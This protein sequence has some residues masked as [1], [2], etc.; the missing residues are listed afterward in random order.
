MKQLAF[1]CGGFDECGWADEI[2]VPR[3]CQGFRYFDSNCVREEPSISI[4]MRPVASLQVFCESGDICRV[5]SNGFDH[6]SLVY[7]LHGSR[8]FVA[9]QNGLHRSE[10]TQNSKESRDDVEVN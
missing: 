6:V 3:H 7:F 1:R 10:N 9:S 4:I 8:I 5:N 2:N